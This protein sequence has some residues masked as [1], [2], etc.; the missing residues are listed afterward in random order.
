[1]RYIFFIILVG[2]V[3]IF[4]LGVDVD[5]VDRGGKPGCSRGVVGSEHS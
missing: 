2:F 5:K 1:M 3:G 4:V